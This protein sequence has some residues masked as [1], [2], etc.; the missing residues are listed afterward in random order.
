MADYVDAVIIM[1]DSLEIERVQVIGH[2][3]GGA[4]ALLVADKR[5]DLIERLVLTSVS[6]FVNDAQVQLY[7]SV[8]TAFRASMSLRGKWMARLP[9][10]TQMMAS[11]Y[12]YRIPK[13]EALLRQG[14]Q[15]YLE[16]DAGTATA[17]A[18]DAPSPR[19]PQAGARIRVPTLLIA[20]RQDQVMPVENVNFT[21]RT[22]PGCQVHWIEECGHIPMVEKP[23]EFMALVRGFLVLD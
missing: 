11:R 5:P 14:L 16:L 20:C 22:I 10:V 19:I 21:A 9:G 17:T 2:S 13:D 18:D 7:R 8:M 1:L 12:F 6:F 23:A 3:M 15:E 4:V